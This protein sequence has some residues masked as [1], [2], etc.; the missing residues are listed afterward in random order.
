MA[1]ADGTITARWMFVT[2]LGALGAEY[3]Q[4]DIFTIRQGEGYSGPIE[5]RPEVAPALTSFL[6]GGVALS[7][8]YGTTWASIGGQVGFDDELGQWYLELPFVMKDLEGNERP[9][10]ITDLFVDIY[11]DPLTLKVDTTGYDVSGFAA[12]LYVDGAWAE[13]ARELT[14]GNY[15]NYGEP[16]EL[17]E[18]APLG[19]PPEF[20]QAFL[21]SK[22]VV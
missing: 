21:R 9:Y 4:F 8:T 2:D 15:D 10:N 3:Y 13:I 22:E 12:G 14:G 6:P 19:P 11:G 16:L 7:Q 17:R 18:L 5:Y 20:W 1:Y